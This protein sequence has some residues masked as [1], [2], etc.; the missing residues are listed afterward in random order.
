MKRGR[1]RENCTEVERIPPVLSQSDTAGLIQGSSN[2]QRDLEQGW[3]EL[4]DYDLVQIPHGGALA[5]QSC[6]YMDSSKWQAKKG[7]PNDDMVQ[8]ISERLGEG[9]DDMKES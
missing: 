7:T 9:Q 6:N 8:N 3:F 5:G 1:R 2:K 4:S